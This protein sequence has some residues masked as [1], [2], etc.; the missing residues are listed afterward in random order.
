MARSARIAV[1]S[2]NVTSTFLW[3]TMLLALFVIR[4]SRADSFTEP[5]LNILCQVIPKSMISIYLIRFLLL[6]FPLIPQF[7]AQFWP[8]CL[9][10]F[11]PPFWLAVAQKWE[12]SLSRQGRK[13][14]M[15]RE[16]FPLFLHGI[17]ASPR[18]TPF[19]RKNIPKIGESGHLELQYIKRKWFLQK[20]RYFC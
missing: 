5:S 12:F 15:G 1:W 10:L 3:L 18:K 7:I 20:I 6:S 19:F 4:W 13:G 16:S 11:T 2:E 17:S 8:I 14:R 9:F